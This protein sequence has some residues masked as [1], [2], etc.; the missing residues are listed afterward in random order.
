MQQRKDSL[1]PIDEA[2]SGLGGPV[3][4]IRETRPPAR[5]VFTQADQVHQLVS[6]GFWC[7]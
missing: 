1:I 2:L 4:A 6:A 3:Q 7:R 5:R